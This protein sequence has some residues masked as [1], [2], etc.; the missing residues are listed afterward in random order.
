MAYPNNIEFYT[1]ICYGPSLWV[2]PR[3]VIGTDPSPALDTDGA[4]DVGKTP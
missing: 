4:V 2:E 3:Y 1:Y